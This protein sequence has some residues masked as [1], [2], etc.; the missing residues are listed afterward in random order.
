MKF[1]NID[2]HISVIADIK[3]LFQKKGHEIDDRCL[4]GHAFIMNRERDSIP[5]LDNNRW[6][7][8]IERQDW[9]A[10][11]D[12]YNEELS[13][14]D[15]FIV[16]YPP[17]FSYLY[18]RFDRPII[19]LL[20]IRYDYVMNH[21][22]EVLQNYINYL[23]E[24]ADAGKIILSANNRYDQRY[25]ENWVDREVLHIPSLCLYTGMQYDADAVQYNNYL[26]YTNY[27]DNNLP[28]DKSKFLLKHDTLP[29]GHSWNELTKFKGIVH[30]PYNVSTMSI[31]EQYSANI[32]LFFPTKRMLL[33]MYRQN[34]DFIPRIVEEHR[35]G[36]KLDYEKR[37]I[38]LDQVSWNFV[39]NRD[40][41]TVVRGKSD[42]D[43]NDYTSMDVVEQFW[44][45]Y[46]DY[47]DD[48]YMPHINY[49]D[50]FDDLESMT[51]N[52]NLKECSEKMRQANEWRQRKVNYMWDSVLER[53]KRYN[54]WRKKGG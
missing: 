33:D 38:A 25:C 20:P 18:R 34:L 29:F 7:G 11:Y 44:I 6:S 12:Q 21:D 26:Y 36:R 35:A 13:D 22:A 53:V 14:I 48:V 9:N 30:F 43:P 10:F 42:L 46:A 47:Y 23:R 3:N 51:E 17:N 1:F 54:C 39:Y 40:P 50:T 49:F 5:L 8:F 31:F 24:G 41:F 2:H 28:I 15:G 37:V 16:C 45:N 4:S 27:G 19:I 32:P 52:I